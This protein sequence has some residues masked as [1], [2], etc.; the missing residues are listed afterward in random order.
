MIEQKIL[1][2]QKTS[3]QVKLEQISMVIEES[4]LSRVHLF[5]II[6]ILTSPAQVSNKAYRKGDIS[7]FNHE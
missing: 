5:Q 4:R 1:A 6:N 7:N 3:C 2:I